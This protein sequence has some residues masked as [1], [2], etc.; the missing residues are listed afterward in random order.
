MPDRPAPIIKTSK[1]SVECS[2]FDI[3]TSSKGSGAE[4]LHAQ[5]LP[6]APGP[7]AAALTQGGSQ[8]AHRMGGVD[9]LR[10]S[11]SNQPRRSLPSCL[12]TGIA[13]GRCLQFTRHPTGL[14]R[15]LSLP[16]DD[17]INKTLP[18]VRAGQLGGS[19]LD[20]GPSLAVE[21]DPFDKSVEM[22]GGQPEPLCQYGGN[23]SI[24][25]PSK[26]WI[27]FYQPINCSF[28]DNP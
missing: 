22:H 6:S 10:S 18:P 16:L 12:A 27:L 28:V 26:G 17:C 3:T 15:G 23:R 20:L 2:F 7:P 9:L 25:P 1:C 24:E 5:N 19:G 4:H 8:P 13:A 21:V 14:A 11:A